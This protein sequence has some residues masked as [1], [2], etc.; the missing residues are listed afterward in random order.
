MQKMAGLF[1]KP[2]LRMD[3]KLHSGDLEF[4]VMRSSG[5]S[6]ELVATVELVVGVKDAYFNWI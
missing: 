6:M 3:T 1:R 4:R 5:G 2:M